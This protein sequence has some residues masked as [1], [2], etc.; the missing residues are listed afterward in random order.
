MITTY[1]Q[2]PVTTRTT[3]ATTTDPEQLIQIS[4]VHGNLRFSRD[5][6]LVFFANISSAMDNNNYHLNWTLVYQGGNELSL[7]NSLTFVT[8][9]DDYCVIDMSLAPAST[10]DS[11]VTYFLTAIISLESTNNGYL[12][13]SLNI[14]L[15]DSPSGGTCNL[16][17]EDVIGDSIDSYKDVSI[18]VMKSVLNITCMNWTD[19]DGTP[20]TYSFS[21]NDS[22]L[23]SFGHGRFVAYTGFSTL[24]FLGSL[25]SR[26]FIVLFFSFVFCCVCLFCVVFFLRVWCFVVHLQF[27]LQSLS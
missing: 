10:F 26:N 7:T 9:Y 1:T 3:T 22:K 25:T 20:L 11:D 4:L 5:E 15:N 13:N 2:A 17:V 18:Y 19:D 24:N 21:I 12:S 8:L 6:R 27:H 16:L 14:S 23:L